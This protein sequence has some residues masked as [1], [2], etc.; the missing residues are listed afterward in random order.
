MAESN[1]EAVQVNQVDGNQNVSIEM[2][3]WYSDIVYYFQHTKCRDELSENQKRTIKLQ[4]AKYV[5]I[6]GDLYWKNQDGILLFCLDAAQSEVILK[7][8]HEGVC[9][10]HFS[11]RTTMHKIL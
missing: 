3:P 11:A 5:L 9:S 6:Q 4:A 10:G 7:E 1:L 8:M 2:C